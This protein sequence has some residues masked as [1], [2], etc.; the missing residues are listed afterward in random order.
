MARTIR[1]Q[2]DSNAHDRPWRVAVEQ[3]FF[4]AE[5]LDRRVQRGQSQRRRRAGG[6]L[7]PSAGRSRSCSRAPSRSI[8]CAN[9]APSSASRPWE[10]A[11][12]SASTRRYVPAP[13]WY[14]RAHPFARSPTCAMCRSR[15]R[16]MPA[17]SMPPSRRWRRWA[18]RSTRSS[19]CT[20]TIVSRRSS[21][22]QTDAAALMEPL[23][24]R[25]AAAGCHMIAELRWR[26][27]IVAS[28]DVDD[29]TAEKITRAL[30]RAVRLAARERGSLA[31]RNPAR[32][33]ARATQ[34]RHDAG[35]GR[36]A[37]RIGR[38]N[39]RRRSTG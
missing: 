8:R 5:G 19:S 1:L 33:R 3:G 39:S 32:P 6:G 15:S 27:G 37:I 18:S 14:A 17:P 20:P 4:A 13:S 2:S 34:Q 10:R 35:A 9:G 22:G 36:R 31:R 24:S 16:G 26:G 28:D 21:S 12:S 25:A 11:R 30:N 23:V 29:E 38:P 7:S